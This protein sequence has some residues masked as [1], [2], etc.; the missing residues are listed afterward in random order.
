MRKIFNSRYSVAYSFVILFLILSFCVRLSLLGLS[1]PKT[2]FSFL[3]VL[4]LFAKGFIYD[5]AV[6]VYFSLLYVIYLLLIPDRWNRS[7]FN[8]VV[9]YIGFCL[10][11]LIIMFSFFAEFAFWGE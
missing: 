1:L 6:A 7:P 11:L 9:T 4:T 8:R 5:L 3:S 10:V 2:S